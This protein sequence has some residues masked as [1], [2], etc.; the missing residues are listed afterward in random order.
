MTCE[1]VTGGEQVAGG[2]SAE[3]SSE[4]VGSVSRSNLRKISM[5]A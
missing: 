1:Q 3:I 4:E 2:T 5:P